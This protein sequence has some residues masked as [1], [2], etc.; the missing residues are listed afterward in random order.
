MSTEY[1]SLGISM[2][3]ATDDSLIVARDLASLERSCLAMEQFQAAYGWLTN[4]DKSALFLLNV[5]DP[6]DSHSLPS[7]SPTNPTSQ[8]VCRHSVRVIHSHIEFLRVRINDPN[9]QFTKIRDIIVSFALPHLPCQLPLTVLRRI[10]SQCLISRVRP[11]LAFQPITRTQA[12]ELDHLLARHIHEYYHFPFHFNSALLTL[13]VESFGF[14]FPS[15]S[16]LNSTLA[17]QGMLRDLSHHILA[18]RTMAAITLADW[19]CGLNH[20]VYPLDGPSVDR[21]FSRCRHSLP[22][23]W[24]T[25]HDTLRG[26]GLTV[27]TT[28][29]S[30]L[31]GD[32]ALRHLL[33][34]CPSLSFPLSSY[35]VSALETEG[36]CRLGDLALVAQT[37]LPRLRLRLSDASLCS[38][39]R[40]LQCLNADALSNIYLGMRPEQ[41]AL[42]DRSSLLYPRDIRRYHT[43][44]ALLGATHV[45]RQLPRQHLPDSLIACDG[46]MIPAQGTPDSVRSVTF[47][48]TTSV[49]SLTGS[50]DKY[51]NGATILHGELYGMIVS[52]LLARSGNIDNGTIH[53]DHLNAI[54]VINSGLLAP[55]LPHAWSPLPARSLYRWLHSIISSSAKPPALI[56]VKAHT[57]S[58][59]LPARAN[60]LVDAIAHDS[61]S[62]VIR[63]YPVP[64]ATFELDSF[65]LYSPSL[66]FIESPLPSLLT[67]I[68]CNHTAADPTFV[69]GRTLALPLYDLHAPPDHPYVRTP[70]AYSALVQL[71]AR[72][73]QLDSA[74]VRFARMGDISPWCQFGCECLETPHHL[75]VKCRR[76]AESR[77]KSSQEV[78]DTTS[79]LL[80]EAKTTVQTTDVYLHSARR[81][82]VDDASVWPLRETRYYLGTVPAIQTPDQISS[83]LATKI[84]HVWHGASIRLAGQIWGMYKRT[85]NPLVGKAERVFD[86]PRH[87]RHL[88]SLS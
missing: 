66:K 33:R 82:F 78:V 74:S 57:D 59:S 67:H 41:P 30:F 84:A 71:Y 58:S 86:L 53:S 49:G 13:P 28:D 27:P 48:V 29:Q 51:A 47:A 22:S 9:T 35:D 10:I 52:A 76:F 24:I 79:M 72:S 18:F 45:S 83:V 43:E 31:L 62:Q 19:M 50:L 34:A 65:V 70:Y 75:F 21:S 36:Y 4:W 54:R 60:A 1:C 2:C 15:I 68:L 87:L 73:R 12:V 46:S 7:V 42:M 6:P 64:Y 32:V 63:P 8:T 56:H 88:Q 69:P 77:N 11:L 37:D 3:E 80:F 55:L 44:A 38:V 16:R 23:L 20:C 17:L 61:H 26:A 14:G 5:P 25:A 39:G 40:W 81:L 85:T